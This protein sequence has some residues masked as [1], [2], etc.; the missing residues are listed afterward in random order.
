MEEILNVDY[1]ISR[2][3]DISI[4]IIVALIKCKTYLLF[5]IVIVVFNF[6]DN[7]KLVLPYIVYLFCNIIFIFLIYFFTNDPSYKHYLS[8]TVDRLLLQTSGIYLI[9]IYYILKKNLKINKLL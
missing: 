5:F 9:P 2:T 1:I 7:F 3:S 8:T 4:A 6:K